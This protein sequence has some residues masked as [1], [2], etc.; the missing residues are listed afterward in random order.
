MDNVL[1]YI[2]C[3]IINI[4]NFFN[5]PELLK[6]VNIKNCFGVFTTVKRSKEQSVG[7]SDNIHGCIGYYNRAPFNNLDNNM[8]FDYLLSSTQSA[9]Y[10]DERSKLFKKHLIFDSEAKIEISLMKNPLL[11]I[12]PNNGLIND[13]LIRPFNNE[14]YGIIIVND[15]NDKTATFLPKVFTKDVSWNYIREKILEK[16]N[17]S[18][19]DNVYYK[20]YKIEKYEKKL[21]DIIKP[22][23]INNIFINI[24]NFF[25][26]NY[27]DKI[28]YALLK[29][30]NSGN[31][32]IVSNINDDVRNIA[33]LND[34]NEMDN[35][36]K[37]L[38]LKTLE[39]I[40]KNTNIYIDKYKKNEQLINQSLSFLILINKNK[41]ISE[42]ICSKLLSNLDNMERNFELGQALIAIIKCNDNDDIIKSN[43]EMM[44]KELFEKKTFNMDDIF[45]ISWQ[46]KAL[47]TYIS[48]NPNRI[49]D[50][51]NI[52]HIELLIHV[53]INVLNTSFNLL[54]DIETNYLAVCFECLSTLYKYEKNNNDLNN[55]LFYIF[56][57]LQSRFS[58]F[59]LYMFNDHT[60]RIDITGH[61]I[62]GFL[63]YY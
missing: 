37:V 21:I 3:N 17:L 51:D 59:G 9:V 50:R 14:E 53:I 41:D 56:I 34:I 62:Q 32:N 42:D 55:I 11:S 7:L 8:I 4:P 33:T 26:Q 39:N 47:T 44:K 49:N 31:F 18:I 13:E 1:N 35:K 2:I 38:S 5:K 25:N 40:E 30:D 48:N 12:N 16:A 54:Y 60:A 45:R 52:V 46:T 36:Y 15:S 58:K 29:A 28:P 20:A 22:N 10:K 43:L 57:I 27:N 24:G 23:Y 6:Y 63:Q 19:N 61:C